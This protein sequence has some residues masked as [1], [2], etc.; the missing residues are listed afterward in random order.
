MCTATGTSAFPAGALRSCSGLPRAESRGAGDGSAP[1]WAVAAGIGGHGAIGGRT[2]VNRLDRHVDAG[3]VVAAAGPFFDVPLDA[4][5]DIV[6]K[7][8]TAAGHAEAADKFCL[9]DGRASGDHDG[10]DAGAIAGFN[11]EDQ[12][13]PLGHVFGVRTHRD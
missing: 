3:F 7:K 12:R 10:A 5:S 11:G 8:R 13:R 2:V 6:A 4:L 9:T 1:A